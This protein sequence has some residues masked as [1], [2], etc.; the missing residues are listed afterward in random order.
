MQ[1]ERLGDLKNVL[2]NMK[3]LNLSI[4]ETTLCN[5]KLNVLFLVRTILVNSENMLWFRSY[6]EIMTRQSI[7]PS[8][9]HK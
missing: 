8:E 4:V 6:W 2:L 9:T 1:R 3:S 5:L 7:S